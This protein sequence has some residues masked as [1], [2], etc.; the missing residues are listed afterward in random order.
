MMPVGS[1]WQLFIPQQ[2]AY[3]SRNA[4]QIKPFSALIFD[5]ELVGIDKPATKAAQK[6]VAGKDEK[7]AK[8]APKAKK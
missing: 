1:K 5:V 2:L 8:P 7:G 4:G 6:P 3:G